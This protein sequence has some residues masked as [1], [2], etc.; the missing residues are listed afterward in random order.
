MY[1]EDGSA[2]FAFVTFVMMNDSF[3]PA[4]LILAYGL[5]QQQCRADLVCMV[6]E[7]VTPRARDVL[8]VLFDSVIDVP[9]FYVAHKETRRR[10]DRPLWFTRLN[11]LRLGPDGDLGQRYEKVCILDADVIPLRHFEHLFTLRAPAGVLNEQK[12]F[13]LNMDDKGKF[14]YPESIQTEGR[15]NWH[16]RYEP[17]C[18]HG[19]RIPRLITDRVKDDPENLGLNGSLYVFDTSQQEFHDIEADVQRDSIRKYVGDLFKWPDMQYLT[20][21]YSGEWTSVDIKYSSFHGYPDLKTICGSH[22]AGF[23]PWHFSKK[24]IGL[25]NRFQDFQY[26]Y[27]QFMS[28][29]TVDYPD[30]SS[31]PA[32]VPLIKKIRRLNDGRSA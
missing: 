29:V 21:R 19:C 23:K 14:T 18:A 11:S 5:R 26:W 27:S 10:E 1:R 6:T 4:A 3:V 15:W 31:T 32:L 30:L 2:R 12:A 25:Y 24:S 17:E 22:Y 28:M 16:D 20:M 13:C 7:E 8:S 9:R